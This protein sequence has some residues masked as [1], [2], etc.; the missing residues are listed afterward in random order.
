MI[1]YWIILQSIF[2]EGN[3]NETKHN[4]KN[5]VS[6]RQ[7]RGDHNGKVFVEVYNGEK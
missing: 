2:N 4:N 3:F 5:T 1:G 6:G 7:N